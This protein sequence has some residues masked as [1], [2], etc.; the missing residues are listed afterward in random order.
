VRIYCE[1]NYGVVQVGSEVGYAFCTTL[2]FFFIIDWIHKQFFGR[3]TGV[4]KL[5]A[6][7]L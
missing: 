4:S 2:Y 5:E 3:R 7:K 6:D 1:P